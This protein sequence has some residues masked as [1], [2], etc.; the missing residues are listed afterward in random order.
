MGSTTSKILGGCGIGCLLL[1]I[2]TAGLGFM[3]YQWAKDATVAVEEAGRIEA[4]LEERYGK[5]RSFVPYPGP[6]IPVDRMEAFLGV[7]EGLAVPR[8]E[9]IAAVARLAQVGGDPGIANGFRAAR[10]GVS[11]APRILEYS[12][13][14]NQALLDVGMGLGE[15]TWM[16]WL[17]YQAWLGHPADDSE[18]HDFM[19]EH[20]SGDS[21]VQIHIDGGMD[22]E[23]LT[24]R[25][26][27][28]VRALMRNLATQL[29][30]HP[31]HA[32][33]LQAVAA[34]LAVSD[35]NPGRVPWQ[36]G[37]PEV[38][39]IGL[40]PYRERLEA[41]YSKATNPFELVELG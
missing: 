24:W 29:E 7:R 1:V 34:E 36:E 40:E 14:R 28:D 12:G 8:D 31:E 10:A 6:G 18:L 27:R 17:T 11:L 19:E 26:R 15:Y 20:N 13:A 3:G 25:L 21:S 32:E 2:L 23:L 5:V 9:L 37:L 41:T 4:E 38:F 22:P 39:A 30:G 35:E 16:Y 33:L